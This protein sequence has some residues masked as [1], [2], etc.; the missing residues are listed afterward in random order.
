MYGN[1]LGHKFFVNFDRKINNFPQPIFFYTFSMLLY[2]SLGYFNVNI[3]SVAICLRS[4]HKMT[5]LFY[6][7]VFF[8]DKSLWGMDWQK[9]RWKQITF[10]VLS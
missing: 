10:V 8:T 5:G 1:L 3:I 2:Y 4:N 6:M 9:G 7:R